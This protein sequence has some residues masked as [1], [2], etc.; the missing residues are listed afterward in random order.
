M[1]R[2]VVRGAG[3]LSTAVIHKLHKSGYKVIALE[4]EKPLAIRRQVSFCEAVYEGEVE[5]EGVKCKL[6]ND[7]D[8]IESVLDDDKVPLIIDPNCQTLAKIQPDVLVDAIIAKYNVGTD[9]S[10]APTTIALGPGF[11]AGKDVDMVVETMRGHN[12]GRIITDGYA[13]PNTGAPG[14]IAGITKERVVYAGCEGRIENV[15]KIGDVVEKDQ[16]ICYIRDEETGEKHEIRATISGVLRG[17]LKDGLY[18][19]NKLKIL[20]IDPRIEEVNNSFTISDKGRCIAGGVLEAVLRS[21]V[22]PY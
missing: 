15:S 17:L 6:C 12:L 20:D 11:C 13:M 7:L 14:S 9:K 1:S 22:L 4:I 3:D 19:K 8:E 10:M 18:A 5:V 2:I 16:I 21:K